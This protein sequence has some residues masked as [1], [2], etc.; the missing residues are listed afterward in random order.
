MADWRWSSTTASRARCCW[1]TVDGALLPPLVWGIQ[2]KF[3]PDT[4][5]LVQASHPY[6]AA[7]YIR[8]YDTFRE[9]VNAAGN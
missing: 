6:D 2:Y 9:L 4:V 1:T 8:D 3:E 7:D 5:L